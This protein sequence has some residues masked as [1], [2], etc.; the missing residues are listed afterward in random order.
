MISLAL[1]SRESFRSLESVA[2]G[3]CRDEPARL[4][5]RAR[6]ALAL[7]DRAGYAVRH[8]PA[9]EQRADVPALAR[10]AELD[11]E[12]LANAI[13]GGLAALRDRDE[14]EPTD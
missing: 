8:A 13:L 1:S 3:T 7:V 9:G 5:A 10:A 6:V 2:D 12:A 4:S 11:P 14:E